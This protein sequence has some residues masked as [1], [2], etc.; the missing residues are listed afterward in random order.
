MPQGAGGAIPSPLPPTGL[1]TPDAGLYRGSRPASTCTVQPDGT[2]AT[3]CRSSAVAWRGALP[4]PTRFLRRGRTLSTDTKQA[5]APIAAGKRCRGWNPVRAS[6][7]GFV[8]EMLSL[9]GFWCG[10]QTIP[11]VVGI[12]RRG[13]TRL[14]MVYCGKAAESP[15]VSTFRF[16]TGRFQTLLCSR[17]GRDTNGKATR[18]A[19]QTISKKQVFNYLLRGGLH[20]DGK[21]DQ[22]ISEAL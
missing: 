20:S 12:C 17:C 18:A 14:L 13:C 4:G 7:T 3:P 10:R 1:R 15:K 11:C 5:K 9:S 8:Y 16:A 2:R 21:P 22:L 19:A 6:C